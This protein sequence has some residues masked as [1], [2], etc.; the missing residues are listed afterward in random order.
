MLA[1][2]CIGQQYQFQQQQGHQRR[3][4]GHA[5]RDQ[6]HPHRRNCCWQYC[7][8][9]GRHAHRQSC[10]N[11]GTKLALVSAS[12]PT[13][14]RK[15]DWDSCSEKMRLALRVPR[16]STGKNVTGVRSMPFAVAAD[17]NIFKARSHSAWVL[18]TRLVCAHQPFYMWVLQKRGLTT[19]CNHAHGTMMH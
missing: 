6:C 10:S 7:C 5:E 11:S 1:A 9:W 17:K 16:T 2:Y 18:S 19:I 13:Y 14:L 8:L 4:H 12:A 15:D 3:S